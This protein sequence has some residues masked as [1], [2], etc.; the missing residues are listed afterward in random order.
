MTTLQRTLLGH[1]VR[2]T[3]AIYG[4]HLFVGLDAHVLYIGKSAL[5][6]NVISMAQWDPRITERLFSK[7]TESM[8]KRR[9]ISWR[10]E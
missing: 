4:E 8:E 1:T 9:S 2:R 10:S 5:M 7:I 3:D 6:T